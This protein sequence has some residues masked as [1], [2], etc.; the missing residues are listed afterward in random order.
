[1]VC[2]FISNLC[3]N[4]ASVSFVFFFYNNVSVRVVDYEWE[5]IWAL[6]NSD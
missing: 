3:L 6:A 5:Y 2:N 4:N 1:M